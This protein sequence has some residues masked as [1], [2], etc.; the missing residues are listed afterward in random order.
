MERTLILI[1]GP[2]GAGKSNYCAALA[3]R[4]R[5]EGRTLAG[6]LSPAVFAQ[7]EKIAIDLLDLATDERRRLAELGTSAKTDVLIGK[8]HFDPAVLEWGNQ[9]LRH[10]K[11]CELLFLDELG[12]LEFDQGSGLLEGMKLIDE[13]RFQQ[14]YVVIRPHL[15]DAAHKRWPVTQVI[16]VSCEASPPRGKV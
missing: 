9:I 7:G 3:S 8:W 4:L 2:I 5:S 1:T 11:A 13:G 16:D 10:I 14:A 12:P 6:L 15:L